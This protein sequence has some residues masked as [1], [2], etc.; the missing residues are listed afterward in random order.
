M[1]EFSAEH[2][3]AK[4]RQNDRTGAF[5]AIRATINAAHHRSARHRYPPC[6]GDRRA[7]EL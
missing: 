6:R 7:L 1:W 5:A 3:P 2:D 4:Q